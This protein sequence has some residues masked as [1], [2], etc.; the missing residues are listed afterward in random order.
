MQITLCE[1]IFLD[2]SKKNLKNFLR[3]TRKTSREFMKRTGGV[4]HA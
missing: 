3:N 4:L 2:I 1:Y